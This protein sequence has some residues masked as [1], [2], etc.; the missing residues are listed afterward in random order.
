MGK[1][2]EEE[3]D[4]SRHFLEGF[5]HCSSNASSPQGKWIENHLGN[6]SVDRKLAQ[7]NL[8]HCLT[9]TFENFFQFKKISFFFSKK[10]VP[11]RGRFDS[12]G[13]CIVFVNIVSVA[14]QSIEKKKKNLNFY[15]FSL[16]LYSWKINKLFSWTKISCTLE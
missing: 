12:L 13:I 4:V 15:F 2:G 5:P 14:Y 8:C 6:L 7:K 1:S 10:C 16:D 3:N 9:L 11:Q